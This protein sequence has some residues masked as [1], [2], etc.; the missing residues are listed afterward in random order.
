MTRQ[1]AGLW[2]TETGVTLHHG[3]QTLG[4]TL[5]TAPSTFFTL[6]SNCV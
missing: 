2:G 5:I 4:M 6:Q 3:A 1:G